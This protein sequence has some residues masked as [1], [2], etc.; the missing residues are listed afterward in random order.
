MFRNDNQP[1][2]YACN[3][4][5]SSKPAIAVLLEW[6]HE[7]QAL[8]SFAMYL[9]WVPS[10][11]NPIADAISREE[12]SRFHAAAAANRYPLS[13]L[14]EIQVPARSTIVSLMIS[15][16]RSAASMRGPP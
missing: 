9:D 12:W 1:W 3:G 4:N 13:A 7:L 8:Y 6:L 14:Q 15:A 11:S 2:C 16:K 10:A 5:D